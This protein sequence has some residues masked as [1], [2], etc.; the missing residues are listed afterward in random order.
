MYSER[1]KGVAYHVVVSNSLDVSIHDGKAKLE[2]GLIPIFLVGLALVVRDGL[3][4]DLLFVEIPSDRFKVAL[5]EILD[6]VFFSQNYF[7]VGK[8][9]LDENL[10][11]LWVSQMHTIWI[12][13]CKESGSVCGWTKEITEVYAIE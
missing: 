12:H 2:Q 4:N 13:G 6:H 11:R 1:Q 9:V 7:K 10:A 8:E 5:C 3:A